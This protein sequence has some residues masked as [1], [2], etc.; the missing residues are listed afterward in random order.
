MVNL[1]AFTKL[2]RL[3]VTPE[4]T[5]EGLVT[6]ITDL[7]SVLPPKFLVLAAKKEITLM[8]F[9][10]WLKEYAL[11]KYK[12]HMEKGMKKEAEIDKRNIKIVKSIYAIIGSIKVACSMIPKYKIKKFMTPS[13]LAERLEKALPKAKEVDPDGYRNLKLL[14]KLIDKYPEWWVK[15]VK[16]FRGI[17]LG[18]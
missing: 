6:L 5:E 13:N 8:E 17:F 3:K 4:I 10:K 2:A 7:I 9:L 11:K 16:E 18:E 1:K 15:Q 12:E 14:L